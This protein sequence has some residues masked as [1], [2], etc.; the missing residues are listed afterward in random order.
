[1]EG[2]TG[3]DPAGGKRRETRFEADASR[4]YVV[5]CTF[6]EILEV[7]DTLAWF[8]DALLWA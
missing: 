5:W 2:G 7:L 8:G 3:N 6:G 4:E 1:M